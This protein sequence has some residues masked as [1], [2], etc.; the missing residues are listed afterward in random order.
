MKL[1]KILKKYTNAKLNMPYFQRKKHVAI[2]LTDVI[3]CIK[4]SHCWEN[5]NFAYYAT[6]S[7]IFSWLKKDRNSNNNSIKCIS[8]I[9]KYK[10]IILIIVISYIKKC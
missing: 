9:S 2:H 6:R 8:N 1:L 10:L 7:Q 5:L 3:L 4:C